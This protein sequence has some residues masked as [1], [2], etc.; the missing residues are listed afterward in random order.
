MINPAR[1]LVLALV[2]ALSLGGGALAQGNGGGNGGGNGNGAD[3]GNAGGNGNGNGAENGNAGGNGNQGAGGNRSSAN[4]GNAGGNG[5]AGQNAETRGKLPDIR[6]LSE[7]ETE[8]QLASGDLAPLADV[9]RT[10]QEAHAGEII[11]TSLVETGGFLL[12]QVKVF[13]AGGTVRD[14]YYYA[15]TGRPVGGQ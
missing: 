9:L 8:K 7:A 11:G 6:A 5:S 12:F 15:G 13:E 1:H 14:F 3:N 2:L 10:A 4:N